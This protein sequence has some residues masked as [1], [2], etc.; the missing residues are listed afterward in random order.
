MYEYYLG[1]G[2][3]LECSISKMSLYPAYF[4]EAIYDGIDWYDKNEDLRHL[5]IELELDCMF[6]NKGKSRNELTDVEFENYIRFSKNALN[7]AEPK[8]ESFISRL[9]SKLFS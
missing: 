5:T 4:Q 1:N 8:K 6:H 7:K 3:P 9:I 2:Y